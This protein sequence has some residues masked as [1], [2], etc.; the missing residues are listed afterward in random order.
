MTGLTYGTY[1]IYD[2]V[3]PTSA[4]VVSDHTEGTDYIKLAASPKRGWNVTFD[5]GV[6]DLPGGSQYA[7]C[8]GSF[9]EQYT[10]DDTA[11]ETQL[12]L[13]EK[14]VK[15][16]TQATYA[17]Y[18]YLVVCTADTPAVRNFYKNSATPY[19]YMP[20]RIS[21]SNANW[22]ENNQTYKVRITVTGCWSS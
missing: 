15:R 7:I 10:I 8:M 4:W 12:G 21:G 22:D 5:D 13:I 1:I 17:P 18:L 6:N 19:A 20:V 2:T 11:T 9:S 3:A 16:N 14:F